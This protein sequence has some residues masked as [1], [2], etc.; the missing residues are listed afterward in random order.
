MKKNITSARA[1]M[2][3]YM[4]ISCMVLPFL[5]FFAGK[6]FC[7][8]NALAEQY[9]PPYISPTPGEITIMACGGYDVLQDSLDEALGRKCF[10]DLRECGVNVAQ[11]WCV[12]T[13]MLSLGLKCAE[14]TGVKIMARCR[15]LIEPSKCRELVD[16]YK[17]NP[18]VAG[19]MLVDEP[20]EKDFKKIAAL[21]DLIEKSDTTRM[22]YVNLLGGAVK[23]MRTYI[24]D[25]ERDFAPAVWSYDIYPVYISGNKT[26]FREEFYTDLELFSEVSKKTNRPFWAY[27]LTLP[28]KP[29]NANWYCPEPT[30]ASMRLSAF[31]ALAYGAQGICYWAYTMRT[32]NE[33]EAYFTAPVLKDGS[34]TK[35][36]YMMKRVNEEIK[37]CNDIFCGCE[38]LDVRHTGSKLARE[39][40][41]FAGSMGM[42]QSVRSDAYGVLVSHLRNNGKEYIVVV[43]RD[44]QKKQKVSLDFSEPVH[45]IISPDSS[46]ITAIKKRENR[47]Y[48]MTLSPGS[49]A[50]FCGD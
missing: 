23:D 27:V 16:K 18:G 48:Q 37:S 10:R 34:R 24:E 9:N 42:L 7:P 2:R 15:M 30:L 5:L 31:A 38:V 4:L 45:D 13:A 44:F 32:T 43:N 33:W 1:Q 36:W 14:G 19:W 47:A 40:K 29:M 6:V 49:Y 46:G 28:Y 17:G 8:A 22:V 21:K 3:F 26:Y 25:F 50:I 35:I 12:D 11:S 20:R 41:P 39:V